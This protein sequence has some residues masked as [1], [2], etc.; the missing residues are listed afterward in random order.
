MVVLASGQNGLPVLSHAIVVPK[1][2]FASVIH[3]FQCTAAARVTARHM[4]LNVAKSRT[5]Q[6]TILS[7]IFKLY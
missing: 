7:S 4:A 1:N 2:E 6:V 5:V 3:R